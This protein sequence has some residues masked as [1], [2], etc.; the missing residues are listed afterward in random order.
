MGPAVMNAPDS[1]PRTQDARWSLR[2]LRFLASI[3]PS[4]VDKKSVDG[5]PEV[6]LCNYTDVY[7]NEIV[8]SDIDFMPAT[9]TRSQVQRFELWRGD[10]LLTKDSE[11]ADDIAV[12]ALVRDDLPGVLCGYHLALLRPLSGIEGRFLA[13][14][15]RTAPVRAQTE[16]AASGITRF[17]LSVGALSDLVVP[18]PSH[19]EQCAIADFLDRE[20]EKIDALVAKKKRLIELLK[21]KRSALISH[22]VTKGLDPAAPLKDS[23]IEWLGQIPESWSILPIRR[24]AARVQTGSTPPTGVDAYYEDGEIPWYGPGSFGVDLRLADPVKWIA[25]SAVD[26][27]AARVFDAGSTFVVCIGATLGKV[28]FVSASSSANQQITAI[29]WRTGTV[30]PLYGALQ[31][32]SLEPLLSGI[33]PASTL[34]IL[35]QSRIA[36]VPI[37]VPPLEQQ[38]QIAR[39]ICIQTDAIDALL[40]KLREATLHLGEYRSA[41]ITA[42]VTGQID[43]REYAKEAG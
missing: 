12:A 1:W 40:A 27:G 5:E 24:L 39:W 10:V 2:R 11:T 37:V 34:P 32:K 19:L 28:G 36:G 38:E 8:S 18:T 17:A 26:A 42:A 30:D 15:L 41:L 4:N 9:A 13:Y 35:D 16:V 33:A 14:A 7:Y 6:Q 29:T 21:E 20:T 23:G 3:R 25:V 31:M 22:A 43:V